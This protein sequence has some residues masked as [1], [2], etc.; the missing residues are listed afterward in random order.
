MSRRTYFF[1]LIVWFACWASLA[2]AQQTGS[3]QGTVLDEKGK[4]V[5]GATVTA[6]QTIG[7]DTPE[8]TATSDESGSFLITGLPWGK[9]SVIAEKK[10]WGY[11]PTPSVFYG[12]RSPLPA[13][14]ISVAH[15]SANLKIQFRGKAPAMMGTLIDDE[16][17]VAIP[18]TLLFRHAQNPANLLSVE[19]GPNYSVLLPASIGLTLEVSSQGYKTWYFPGT[20]DFAKKTVLRLSPGEVRK[21]NIRL[22][23]EYED[24][25]CL[26]QPKHWGLGPDSPAFQWHHLKDAASQR[27][28][29][30]RH[31]THTMAQLTV[32]A[33]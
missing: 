28:C 17:S 12:S 31:A 16:A 5:S 26:D 30:P 15:P 22:D 9:Y 11:P 25:A 7:N 24:C 21:L 18:A 20:N 27:A 14:E 1:T 10:D 32:I 2:M 3:I 19:S 8:K 29:A 23:G 33:R 4:P 6:A 13:T